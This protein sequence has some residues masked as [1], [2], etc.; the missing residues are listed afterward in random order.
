MQNTQ[1]F[2]VMFSSIQNTKSITLIIAYWGLF[3][4]FLASWDQNTK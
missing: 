2:M 3:G 1:I 4:P